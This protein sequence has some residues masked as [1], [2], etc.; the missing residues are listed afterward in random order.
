MHVAV[1][2]LLVAGVIVGAPR[3]GGVVAWGQQ[4]FAKDAPI[5]VGA[6]VHVDANAFHPAVDVLAGKPVD[7]P[8]ASGVAAGKNQRL[9][10][11]PLR[12]RNNG[13]EPWQVPVAAKAVLIDTLGVSHP[14][15]KTVKAVPSYPL[16][17]GRTA[18]GPGQEVTGYA[19]FAV[20]KDRPLASVRIGL[21]KSAGT[22][23]DA[24]D[25]AVT[26]QVSP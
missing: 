3:V 25:P 23:G 12:F 6:V 8:A 15:A 7:V 4:L 16:L 19:V 18:V 20:P 22:G 17:P 9:V 24:G 14:V 13:T 11:V 10:V 21:S 1:G 26:W 5:T 2:A